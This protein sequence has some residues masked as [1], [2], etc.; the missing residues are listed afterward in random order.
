[1]FP[2]VGPQRITGTPIKLSATPGSP[3]DVAPRLGEHSAE[4]L[5]ELLSLT[6]ETVSSLL[7]A[8]VIVQPES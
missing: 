5:Q 8:G 1:M 4:L 3:G 2:V 6:P 7:A